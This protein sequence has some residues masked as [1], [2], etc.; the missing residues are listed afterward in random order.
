MV[1]NLPAVQET[2]VQSLGREDALEKGTATH[3]S[4][5]A[6]RI[7]WTDKPGVL[8]SMGHKELDMIDIKWPRVWLL[9]QTAWLR[10]LFCHL[11]WPW[12]NYLSLGFIFHSVKQGLGNALAVYWLGLSVFTAEGP[13]SVLGQGTKIP[14]ATWH[15]A[16]PPYPPPNLTNK[17]FPFKF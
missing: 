3:S 17:T 7:P 4:I 6:W 2:H 5:F 15:G 12:A 13:G 11:L 10:I 14:Q 9:S 1:K 8:K 16:A